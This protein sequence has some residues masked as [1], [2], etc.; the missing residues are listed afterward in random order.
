M[1]P[2]TPLLKNIKDG[3]PKFNYKA[4]ATRPKVESHLF[5]SCSLLLLVDL[6]R[7]IKKVY[8]R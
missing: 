7:P 2:R 8:Y 6:L 4:R 1:G 3:T 5:I